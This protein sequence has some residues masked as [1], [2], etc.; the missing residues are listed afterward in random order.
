[1]GSTCREELGSLFGGGK[2]SIKDW[3]IQIL[4]RL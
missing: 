1:M 2:L 3:H 4:G